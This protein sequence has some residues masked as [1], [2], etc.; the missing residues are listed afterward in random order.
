[1]ICNSRQETLSR[2]EPLTAYL[3]KRLGVRLEAVAIDTVDFTEEAYTLDFTHTNSL[4]YVILN[5]FHGV[6]TLAAE[7]SGPLGYRSKGVIITLKKSSIRSV[8]DLRGRTMVFGPMLAPTAYVTQL[9]L[10]LRGGIDPEDHLAFYTIPPG[11]YKHEKVIYGVL[12]EKYDAGAVPLYDFDKMAS[13]NKIDREDFTII[14]E[15][16]AVPYCT[17]GVSQRVE[18]SLARKF[19]AALLD[20]S[21]K[22]TVEI[23][24]EVVKVL[25]RA[26]V[27]GYSAVS[28]KEYDI[29]REMAKR[30][31]MPP[32]QR[33]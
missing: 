16:E 13:E 24:G 31:N 8:E 26:Q 22:D 15:G 33:Y 23:D 27:D 29:V 5:R 12:F 6:E 20:L 2:F 28:D 4:L 3:S 21:S 1:M 30:T 9:D 7:R 32:Y 17:F 14:A 25:E 18:D 11:S 19:K 10:L